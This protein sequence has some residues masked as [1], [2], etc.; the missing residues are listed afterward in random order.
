VLKVISGGI[1]RQINF[2]GVG[3]R[4]ETKAYKYVNTPYY[5]SST[6]KHARSG[7]LHF[8]SSCIH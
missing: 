6:N 5:T 8:D 4:V 7:T 1:P 2:N 3:L